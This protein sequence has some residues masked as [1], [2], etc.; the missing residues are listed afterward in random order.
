MEEKHPKTI[1]KFRDWNNSHHKRILENNEL[2]IPSVNELNDP[3]DCLINYDY[4]EIEKEGLSERVVKMYFEEFGEKIS[5]LG[6][7]REKLIN[8]TD[9][10]TK[11]TLL[12]LKKDIDNSFVGNRKK[13]FGVV[14]FS[15][16]WDILLMWSHYS[17]SHKGFCVGF[18]TK[19]IIESNFF[20]SGCKIFYPKNYPKVNP[21]DSDVKKIVDMFFSKSEDWKH[22]KE[23]RM[24]KQLGYNRNDNE[25]QKQKIFNFQDDFID[26]VILGL[27]ISE[28]DKEEILILCHKKNL[29]VYQIQDVSNKFKITRNRIN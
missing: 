14:S 19:K 1:Y 24:T 18:N 20:Q 10:N 4:S 12:N 22:E 16:I 13:H 28:V 3:F 17:N 26:E 25:F 8:N 23:Y 21:F 7:T 2:Y 29:P 27:T 5:E 9:K 11:L 15:E 6:Y